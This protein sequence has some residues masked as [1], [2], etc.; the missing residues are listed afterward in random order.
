MG[1]LSLMLL[2][3]A[4]TDEAYRAGVRSV[5]DRLSPRGGVAHEEDLGD[6]AVYRHIQE[7]RGP[8]S[9]EPVYDYKMVDDDFL[10][11]I[12]SGR[13][14]GMRVSE[15]LLR[16]ATYVLDL[17]EP[18]FRSAPDFRS[19]VAIR[20][21]EDVGDW[22]DSR[23]GLGG[24]RYPGNVNL[25]L[26]PA[27][28]RAVGSMAGDPRL[29]PRAGQ[30]TEWAQR[31]EKAAGQEYLVRLDREQVRSRLARYL[32]RL[33]PAEREFYRSRPVGEGGPRLAEFLDGG[34][35]PP[36][37]AMGLEFMAL[38]LDADGRPVEVMNSDAPFDL[39]LGTPSRRDVERTL[40]L[41]ELEFPVGL[42]T[43]VG[44]VVANPAYSLDPRHAEQLDR[45]GYHG[46]VIW[47]WQSGMLIAGL[48]R[49]LE[50]YPELEVRLLRALER[51]QQAET[52]AG[53]LA[54]SELWSFEVDGDWRARA[55]S[56]GGETESNPVQLWSTIY[57]A[58]KLRL[59]ETTVP[60]R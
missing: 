40:T 3:P 12:A 50:R 39:F 49:Q 21:G 1:P 55:F 48:L 31:W 43:G 53:A 17:V 38:S 25:Y 47:S 23:E 35:V 58:L 52:R 34:P 30:A 41:L 4:L 27:A 18:F 10:L 45:K 36:A 15:P 37:L 16:N 2:Q 7:N 28:L 20:S 5:L 8:A 44:P 19:T 6:W 33:T 32:E 56:G 51:L 54:N 29:D 13:A 26:V 11:P 9:S 24:G 14:R 60:V 22:R 57:P 46:T 59:L 42:M